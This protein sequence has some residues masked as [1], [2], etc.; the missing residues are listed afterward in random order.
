[1]QPYEKVF[2]NL[3]RKNE[4]AL[5]AFTVIGDPD[6]KTSLEIVK[7]NADAGADMLELG[8][9]FSDPI[10]D[11]PSIQAADIRALNSGMDTDKVF[12]FVGELRRCTDI[13]IGLLTYYNLVYQRGISKFF[14]DAKNA[15]VNS[16]LIADLPIEECNDA[17][18]EATNYGIDMVFM[19]SPLTDDL[20]I[21]KIAEYATGFIY[22]VARLG[23]TGAK[24]GLGKSASVLVK[25]IR[26]FT[27]KPVCVGF[28]ISKPK[29][30]TEVIS[31][32]ADGAIV[33]S[34]VVDLIAK[35]LKNKKQ[36]FEGIYNYVY[37]MKEAAKITKSPHSPN[38]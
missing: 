2:R 20:R 3:K 38:S 17:I 1:M 32:G 14:S 19:V 16:V 10:A 27:D 4:G 8:L 11:G 24:A 6:Y 15:K 28:G 9:P 30:V 26:K 29:H 21:K 5:V 25:R 22:A 7:K 34:A 33:G 18:R 13:P 23:V 37:C 12:K 36:M 31:S 35:N